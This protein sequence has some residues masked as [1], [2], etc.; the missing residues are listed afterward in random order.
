M[1]KLQWVYEDAIGQPDRGIWGNYRCQISTN[2]SVFGLK[3]AFE[4]RVCFYRHEILV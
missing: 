4:L 2:S 1:M 3:N